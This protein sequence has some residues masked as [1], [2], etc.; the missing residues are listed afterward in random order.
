MIHQVL[1]KLDHRNKHHVCVG[2]GGG[3]GVYH[4]SYSEPESCR[5]MAAVQCNS[6][7]MSLPSGRGGGLSL[8][9]SVGPSGTCRTSNFHVLFGE[10]EEKQYLLVVV[11]LHLP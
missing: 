7:S 10:G 8:P 9:P 1:E 2:G 4:M 5:S 6:F 3:G 11:Y